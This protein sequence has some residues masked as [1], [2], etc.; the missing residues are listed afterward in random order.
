M[1]VLVVGLGSMGKRRIRLIRQYD[2]DYEIIGIDMNENRRLEVEKLGI[3][4]F[5]IL[6]QVINEVEVHCAF[7]CTSPLSHSEIIYK[8]LDKNIHVFSEINLVRTGYEKN[9]CMAKEKGK[10]LFL[11]STFLYRHD[12][13]YIINRVNGCRV[14]YIYHTGQYLPDW[15]PWEKIDNYFVSN[16]Q[17]NGCREILT[18]ELPWI[19]KCFGKVVNTTV[20]KDK[21]SSLPLKYPDNY[22]IIFEHE[23]GTKGM[24][25]V[26]VITRKARRNL[27]IYGEDIQIY[28]DGKPDSLFE[29]S[30]KDKTN[31]NIATYDDVQTDSKYCDNIIENAYYDEVATFFAQVKNGQILE[32]HHDFERDI[33]ILELIDRIES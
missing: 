13:Q 33:P 15:H 24:L 6:D 18:I 14:N 21:M 3:K 12:I 26:D 8:L 31:K 20:I 5:S 7:V 25:A 30:I 10:V 16:P 4:C 1:R 23:N 2:S 27:E 19:K 17:T 28:W 32:N 9:I 22:M 11:S 29:Y